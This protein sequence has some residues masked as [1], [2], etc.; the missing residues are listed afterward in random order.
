[1]VITIGNYKID[2]YYMHAGDRNWPLDQFPMKPSRDILESLEKVQFDDDA[3]TDDE[4]NYV[5]DKRN[6]GGKPGPGLP[7]P[8]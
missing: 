3:D 4:N 1:M 6:Q 5:N 2:E 8:S 7:A